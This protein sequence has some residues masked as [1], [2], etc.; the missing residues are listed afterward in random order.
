M[1][2]NVLRLDEALV[3]T[4][5]LR[6]TDFE[7]EAMADTYVDREGGELLYLYESS[8]TDE[9]SDLDAAMRGQEDNAEIR[10]R[11]RSEPSRYLKIEPM[12]HD[13]HH[14]M[15]RSFLASDWTDD[16]ELAEQAGAAYDRSIGR[17]RQAVEESTYNAYQD[18]AYNTTK[19]KI[20][21]WLKSEGIAPNWY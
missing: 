7:Y 2:V 20:E 18:Y 14:A 3:V 9:E 8:S 15:L 4:A 10:A 5:V 1:T 13:D 21:H 19:A 17:W 16:T 11:I 6:D 12:D